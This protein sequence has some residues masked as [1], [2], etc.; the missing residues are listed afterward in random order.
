AGVR[1]K[2]NCQIDDKARLSALQY[3]IGGRTMGQVWKILPSCTV[4]E[5]EDGTGFVFNAD[6]DRLHPLNKMATEL[7]RELGD[8]AAT[9][10]EIFEKMWPHLETLVRDSV[11]EDFRA[12]L[13]AM[14]ERGCVT[15]E[16]DDQEEGVAEAKADIYSPP[17]VEDFSRRRRREADPDVQPKSNEDRM[18]RRRFLA[19][20]A[21]AL[22]AIVVSPRQA[23]A[24]AC[25]TAGGHPPYGD[26]CTYGNGPN[27]AWC[28]PGEFPDDSYCQTGSEPLGDDG[29]CTSTGD[30]P[31]LRDCTAGITP[32]SQGDDVYCQTGFNPEYEQCQ[33]GS[34]PDTESCSEHGY[35]PEVSFCYKGNEPLQNPCFTSGFAPV[36]DQ[37]YNGQWM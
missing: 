30:S 22:V 31:E 37:C 10:E 4:R 15:K 17:L 32:D 18:Q 27:A 33:S 29:R 3:I 23:S 2:N 5:E 16:G 1:D 9:E 35:Q 7:L 21:G 28:N 14:S 19:V 8:G 11:R 25:V 26:P 24:A 34:S 6:D 13:L 20:G 36:N 12:F